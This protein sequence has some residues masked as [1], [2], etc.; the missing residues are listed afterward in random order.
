MMGISVVKT[1][2]DTTVQQSVSALMLAC[3]S[4]A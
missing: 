2:V 4:C 1:T 3:V